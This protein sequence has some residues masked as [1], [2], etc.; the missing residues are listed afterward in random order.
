[1]KPE[2]P[3]TTQQLRKE[4]VRRPLKKDRL[5]IALFFSLTLWASSFPGMK[6][7]LKGYS[8]LELAAFRF[9][10]A[11][12]TLAC[13]AP[14]FKVRWPRYQDLLLILALAF[15]GVACFHV[16]L[17]YGQLRATAGAAAFII[18]IAPVFTGLIAWLFLG[19]KITWRWCIGVLVSLF[20][21][22]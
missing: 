10:I 14:W 7:S 4:L 6:A 11:S 13:V 22:G 9:L 16:I 15:V 5:Y 2:T 12:L 8:P 3:D 20:G 18:N 19:E 21:V 1:M 17:N